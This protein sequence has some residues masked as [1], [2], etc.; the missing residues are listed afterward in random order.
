MK[1]LWV[2]ALLILTTACQNQNTETVA[3]KEQTKPMACTKDLKVCENGQTVGRDMN[4]QCKF[5][6]C[7]PPQEKG[8]CKN[9]MKQCK[10][11]SFVYPDPANQCEFELCPE[12]KSDSSIEKNPASKAC[13]KELK[14]C[15]NGN[16]VGRDSANN[17]EFFP[18]EQPKAKEP[19]MCTQ[20]VKQC[21]DG[22]YVG[23][24]SN[25]GCAFKPCPGDDKTTEPV[26]Q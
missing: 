20:D 6:P 7:P 24:D 5:F 21:P 3:E 19:I 8:T 10:D 25:N 26:D 16:T 12:E 15:K 2:T 23:R 13:T 14:V 18:C 4:N 22:S 1:N 9:E 17:C 11:G